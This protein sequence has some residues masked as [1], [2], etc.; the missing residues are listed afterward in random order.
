MSSSLL[1]LFVFFAVLLHCASESVQEIGFEVQY[2][3]NLE[4]IE[5]VIPNCGIG[6]YV[7]LQKQPEEMIVF[8][9]QFFQRKTNVEHSILQQ[10]LEPVRCKRTSVSTKEEE[11]EG[12][13]ANKFNSFEL[14]NSLMGNLFQTQ[15]SMK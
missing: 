11:E 9:S 6:E 2:T 13:D 14:T 4:C 8:E 10:I 3:S 1:L 12:E 5:M 15:M 7:H